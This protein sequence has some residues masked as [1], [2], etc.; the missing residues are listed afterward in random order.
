HQGLV[1]PK[2][3]ERT[4]AILGVCSLQ[5][6]PARWVAIHRMHHQHSDEHRDPHSPLVDFLWGHMGWLVYRNKYIG[7]SD[8][9]ER[10]APDLAKD[11]FYRRLQ[12]KRVWVRIYLAHALLM[13]AAAFLIGWA[14]SRTVMGG[15]QFGLSILVWGVIVRTVYVWHITWSVNS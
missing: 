11:P 9:Y 8:F 1:V 15:L 4:L 6:A 12:R 7:T 13:V 14:A 2:W 5:D 10:Y 3:L